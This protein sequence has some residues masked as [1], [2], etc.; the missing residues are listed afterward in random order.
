MN[1]EPLQ[2]AVVV[3]RQVLDGVTPA[4][5]SSPTPCASWT[6]AGVLD[7]VIGAQRL[8]AAMAVGDTPS[9][10]PVQVG[11]GDFRTQFD[12]AV[13]RTITAFGSDAAAGRSVTLPFG[14][15]TTEAFVKVAATDLL[16][17][18]WDIARAT[19]QPTDFAPDLAEMLLDNAH[20]FITPAFRGDDGVA[21]FGAVQPIDEGASA[22]DRLAAFLG[23]RA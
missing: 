4:D 23:R 21:F 11:E 9:G 5:L 15:T 14:E 2:Q 1:T 18:T 16:A 8:F 17:H 6:V 20:S 7:H 12:E 3:A 22:A 13:E 19:G 10:D